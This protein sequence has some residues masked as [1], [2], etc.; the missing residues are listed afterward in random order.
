MTATD[1]KILR[2]LKQA[3]SNALLGEVM[4]TPKPGLV[5]RSN[6][7]A[8]RDMNLFTFLRSASAIL[9]YLQEMAETGLSWDASPQELFSALRPAGREAE[10]AMFRATCGV[11]THKGA[12]FSL[13][14]AVAAAGARYRKTGRLNAGEILEFCGEMTGEALE[15]EFARIDPS[16]PATHGERLYLAYGVRGIR[17]EVQRGF[18][19]VREHALPML[20]ELRKQC[21]TPDQ[22][23]V[24]TLLCLMAN[25]DDTNVLH[26]SNLE[27]M[28]RVQARAR[29]A[30]G[31]GGM[32]TDEGR[33]EILRMDRDFICR[34]VSP[35]GCADLLAVAVFA[36]R[37]E[38]HQP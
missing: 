9:P 31:I 29:A 4:A 35:G 18:P 26:R 23:L 25:V 30:L 8:H 33:A 38:M 7:G 15:K 24:Q 28:R 16:N 1:T 11:N 17:G 20:R 2:I 12:I 19:S 34:N 37:L 6:N 21:A 3:A 10:R 36:E 22:A 14:L 32:F 13:G 5:D 27:T